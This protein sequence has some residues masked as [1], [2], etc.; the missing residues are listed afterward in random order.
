MPKYVIV[1]PEGQ[2]LNRYTADAPVPYGYLWMPPHA[3]HREVPAEIDL[4]CAAI[5]DGEVISDP[6]LEAAKIESQWNAL[7]AQRN[8]KLSACD[9]TQLSDSPLDATMKANW[10]TYRQALR[11]LPENT[12]DPTSPSW[13]AEPQA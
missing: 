8:S 13:P 1:N 12:V 11:D 2:V 5:V 3:E 6:S 9:W 10:A 4:D 7:R